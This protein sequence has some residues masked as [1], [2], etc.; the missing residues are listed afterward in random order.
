[1]PARRAGIPRGAACCGLTTS[2]PMRAR[3]SIRPATPSFSRNESITERGLPDTTPSFR[4]RAAAARNASGAPGIGFTSVASSVQRT[5]SS[6]ASRSA[7]ASIFV[8][9]RI[10]SATCSQVRPR[11]SECG[12]AKSG[13]PWRAVTTLIARSVWTSLSTSVPSRSKNAAR[14]GRIAVTQRGSR[15]RGP[16]SCASCPWYRRCPA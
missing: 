13:T 5:S 15:A 12:S 9:T 8:S 14:T 11:V 7:G 2:P 1:M 10:L 16:G 6:S 4:L 3:R